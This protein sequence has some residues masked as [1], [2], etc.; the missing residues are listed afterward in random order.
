MA[1]DKNR[2]IH[3]NRYKSNPEEKKFADA[4]SELC[5]FGH[6]EKQLGD[7][8][9]EADVSDRDRVVAAT[10]IQWLGSPVGESFLRGLGYE[11]NTTPPLP[12]SADS[13]TYR[14]VKYV[15]N[16]KK[17]KYISQTS[18]CAFPP[19][20]VRYEAEGWAAGV[21]LTSHETPQAALD[22]WVEAALQECDEEYSSYREEAEKLMES[23]KEEK[24]LAQRIK[25]R[26]WVKR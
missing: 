17:R 6:L 21:G 20:S 2:G 12:K 5:A 7:G 3:T 18:K 11:G 23:A 13:F 19:P 4:W 8:K 16:R 15:F 1:K 25:A 14:G 22:Y 9:Q 10:V 26:S 24:S